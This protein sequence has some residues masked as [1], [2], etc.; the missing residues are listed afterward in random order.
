LRL[1]PH[2]EV[3]EVGD[4]PR[5]SHFRKLW[6]PA[7]YHPDSLVSL[8]VLSLS[9]FPPDSCGYP[10]SPHSFAL[11]RR[12]DLSVLSGPGDPAPRL[13]GTNRPRTPVWLRPELDGIRPR[14]SSYK[15]LGV[16]TYGDISFVLYLST[17]SIVFSCH[18]CRTALCSAYHHFNDGKG[19]R[20]PPTRFSDVNPCEK[21][22]EP[23]EAQPHTRVTLII[24]FLSVS[25]IVQ[26]FFSCS[27]VYSR[28]KFK[29]HVWLD[30]WITAAGAVGWTPICIGSILLTYNRQRRYFVESSAL[31]R[32][33]MELDTILTT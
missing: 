19:R 5:I 26:L 6:D 27:R 10:H 23:K 14:R 13:I 9:L 33:N 7:G 21:M 31:W 22:A 15:V 28:L 29:A 18:R 20:N 2:V 25:V 24:C 8:V 16:S 1:F 11:H 17:R 32:P 30:D 12:D 4:L 3:G